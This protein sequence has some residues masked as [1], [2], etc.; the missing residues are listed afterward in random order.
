MLGQ[1]RLHPGTQ[2]CP[3][4]PCCFGGHWTGSARASL[5]GGAAIGPPGML[6]VPCGCHWS[7]T[8]AIGPLG[9]LSAPWGCHRSP[10]GQIRSGHTG[11]GLAPSPGASRGTDPSSVRGLA[12]QLPPRIHQE[13]L[14]FTPPPFPALPSWASPRAVLSLFPPDPRG[15]HPTPAPPQ[16]LCCTFGPEAGRERAE[17]PHPPLPAP[18]TLPWHHSPG[19]APSRPQAP[20]TKTPPNSPAPTPAFAHAAGEGCNLQTAGTPPRPDTRPQALSL[21]PGE[22]RGAGGEVVAWRGAPGGGATPGRKRRWFVTQR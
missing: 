10:P 8:D 21:S 3:G 4:V 1:R 12:A 11:E 15:S 22:A 17:H 5:G 7:P 6:P 18:P 2:G 9:M 13:T 14:G 20:T 19:T 16:S